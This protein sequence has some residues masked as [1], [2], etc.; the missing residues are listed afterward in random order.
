MTAPEVTYVLP[1]KVGGALT[2]VA[3]LLQFRRPDNLRYRAVL[4]SNRRDPDT[5]FAGALAVD[6][7][8][9]VE[10]ALPIENLHAVARRVDAAIGGGPGVLVCNDAL[11][12][13]C[14]ALRD[15]GRT[16]VQILHGDYDYYYD[17]AE[18]HEPL[19]HAFV[20]YSRR[21]YET[22]LARL[23]HRRDTIFWLPYITGDTAG[24][25]RC[26]SRHRAYRAW[27][28]GA[29]SRMSK[30]STT[31]RRAAA[32]KACRSPRSRR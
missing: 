14:V 3:N 9:T 6:S 7:Q 27:Y 15:P 5:K 18:R 4:T 16:V 23:P 26:S 21:V 17:L 12:M 1:G 28:A 30:L 32:R 31:S 8:A 11:E 29:R 24:R 20:A 19:V 10:H 13:M 2:I 22:L 25:G